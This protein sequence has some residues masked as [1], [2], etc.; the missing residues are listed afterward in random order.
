MI[1]LFRSGSL[2]PVDIETSMP[3]IFFMFMEIKSDSSLLSHLLNK[4][5][6]SFASASAL[7]LTSSSPVAMYSKKAPS[8]YSFL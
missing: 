7:L 6:S 8:M 2:P 1:V 3:P 5:P 4:M